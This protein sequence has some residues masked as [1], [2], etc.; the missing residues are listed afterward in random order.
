MA[1]IIA[2]FVLFIPDSHS[3]L[4]YLDYITHGS[5]SSGGKNII[6]FSPQTALHTVLQVMHKIL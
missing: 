2:A 6:T 1:R 3:E 5:E 4:K